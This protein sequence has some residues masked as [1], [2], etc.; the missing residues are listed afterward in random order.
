MRSHFIHLRR[1]KLFTLQ[2]KLVQTGQNTGP[3]RI[4]FVKK[5]SSFPGALGTFDYFFASVTRTE[6]IF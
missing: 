2:Q 5:E 4:I 6:P 3:H 1:I